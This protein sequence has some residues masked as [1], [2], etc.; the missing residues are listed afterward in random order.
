MIRCLNIRMLF[1]VLSNQKTNSYLKEITDCGIKKTINF[2]I[3]KHKFATTITLLNE[4]PLES[5][6]KMSGHTNIQTSQH[7]T[8]ILDIKVVAD[9]AF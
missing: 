2:P 3:T 4:I 7:Y 5:P 1:P 6:S 8:K 9:M